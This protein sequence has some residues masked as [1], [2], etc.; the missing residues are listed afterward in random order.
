MQVYV[1]KIYAIELDGLPKIISLQITRGDIGIRQTR[2]TFKPSLFATAAAEEAWIRP[3]R[4]ELWKR[5]LR[6]LH[7][8]QFHYNFG[9]DRNVYWGER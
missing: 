1:K 9:G 6:M 3:R 2:Y 7:N 4:K 5:V 8:I